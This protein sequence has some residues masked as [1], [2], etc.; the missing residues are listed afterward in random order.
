MQCTVWGIFTPNFSS[1]ISRPL[2]SMRV[3]A[4]FPSPAEDYIEGSIDLSRDLIKHR[5]S[6]FYI[7][8]IGDSME[9]LIHSN[10][11]LVVDRMPETNDK[12]IVVARFGND[13]CVKRL[14][15]LNDGSVWLF[16]ENIN[17]K[18]IQVEAEDDFE[19]WGKV[20]HSIQSF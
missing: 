2:I 8:V 1:K 4:G 7:R 16:S 19:I 20:L 17:Y 9:P 13:L 11:L 15:I 6:T 10:D 12:D 5:L 18:P 14:R 3:P